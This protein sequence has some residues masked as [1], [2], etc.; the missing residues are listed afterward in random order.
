MDVLIATMPGSE[1]LYLS[2]DE[3]SSTT[4]ESRT[5]KWVNDDD[6]TIFGPYSS[7]VDA[8]K[9]ILDFGYGI[10]PIR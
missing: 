2:V 7:G 10:S 8:M 5:C 4:A 3:T 6:V 1:D 9:E